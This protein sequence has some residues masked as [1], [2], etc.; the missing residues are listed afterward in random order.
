MTSWSFNDVCRVTEKFRCLT[1]MFPAKFKL[2]DT[3]PSCFMSYIASK[4]PFHGLCTALFST[5]LCFL[6][7][8]LLFKMAPKYSAEVLSSAPKFF[9]VLF[10]KIVY[11][12]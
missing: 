6:L 10:R 5:F 1:H 8:I 3:L 2:G 4:H 7:L 9:I 12:R 11:V